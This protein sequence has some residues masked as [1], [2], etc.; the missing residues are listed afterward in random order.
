MS[1]WRPA[2]R[3]ARRSVR[4]NLKRS[5]LIAALIAVPIGGATLVDGLLR[6][7]T[8][9]EPN[10]E[11][12]LGSADGRVFVTSRTTLGDWQLGDS[13]Y[14]EAGSE[15][16]P[17]MVDPRNLLPPGSRI[18]PVPQ[19]Y[20]LRLR[21]DER[22]VR[23]ELLPFSVGDPLTNHVGRLATGRLP[24]G[25]T[26][27]LV[28]EPLA[29]RL[30]LLD[31][32][33]IRAGATITADD[34]PTVTVTGIGV[35]PYQL[36]QA[37]VFAPTDSALLGAETTF[38]PEPWWQ[39]FVDLPPDTTVDETWPALAEHGVEFQT[40]WQRSGDGLKTTAPVAMVAGLGLLEVVL[41]AGTAFA[42][43]ARRQVREL[44]L[45][46]ANGGTSAHVRRIVLAQGLVLGVLGTL[47]GVFIGWLLLAAGTPVWEQVTNQ[48]I[49]GWRFG[50]LELMVAAVIGLVSGV[51]AAL[52]PAIVVARMRPVDALAQRFR[53]NT[54][55]ARLPVLGMVV[56][57]VGIVGVLGTGLLARQTVIAR[58]AA[59]ENAVDLTTH[60]VGVLLGTVTIVVG[61]FLV[62]PKL[63]TALGR[64]GA[65][66][67]LSGR[68]AL[69]DA[70]RHRHRT[71]PTV[72]AIMVVV[73]GSVTL[74]FS[75]AATAPRQFRTVPD[76]TIV[77]SED[78]GVTDPDAD[79]QLAD[80]TSEI[81]DELPGAATHE[82]Q[83][84]MDPTVSEH[85]PISTSL[86]WDASNPDCQLATSARLGVG[87]PEMIEL[88][89][90]QRPPPAALAA[91]AD[92]KALVTDECVLADGVA[93]TE[94]FND[95]DAEPRQFP[96]QY[97]PMADGNERTYFTDLPDAFISAETAAAHGLTTK[98][99]AIAVVHRADATQDQVDAALSV[100]E[101]QGLTAHVQPDYAAEANLIALAL[102]GGAGL[103]TLLGVGITVAL[104]GAESRADLATLAAI[105][106]QPRRRRTLA[107]AQALVLSTLGTG[108]GLGFG[109]VLGVAVVWLTGLTEI[110]LPWQNLAIT[111]VAVPLLAVAVALVTTRATLPMV[112]R[113][114]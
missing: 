37:A 30:G 4:R 100:A 113:V 59:G 48:L 66:L 85:G 74:A 3:I 34:G 7:L 28:T 78:P 64:S 105:G 35:D 97:L 81:A 103:V 44:G 65:R 101:D 6:T 33:E 93:T 18:V 53:N 111:V 67:P 94:R 106:A 75:L 76:D 42:V 69:R 104:S 40:A 26:E 9:N 32:D 70:G 90:G 16:D 19:P 36:D 24:A 13:V 46:G 95:T 96:A 8:G 108:L 60:I 5:I 61:M 86:A 82:V 83:M 43:G 91:L 29:E 98:R 88:V 77:V 62:A 84:I 55:N 79:A 2:L 58:Q 102:A 50:W 80:A 22:I 17:S 49:D 10:A 38:A 72:I 25:P 12:F 73:T 114:E 107:G 31:G 27:A 41:L 92:G 87:T 47:A 52:L 45:V 63:I 112:R 20:G 57:G 21:E 71:V 99:T 11:R 39:Y 68:L 89:T 109:A 1:G 15:R 56:L 14:H 23:T 51:G 54:G 110:V